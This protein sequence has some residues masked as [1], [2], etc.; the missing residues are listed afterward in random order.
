MSVFGIKAGDYSK[1]AVDARA[2]AR[3]LWCSLLLDVLSDDS[4]WCA[5]AT[6][7]KV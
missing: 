1:A 4:N 7:S 2:L 6:G 5:T 3:L